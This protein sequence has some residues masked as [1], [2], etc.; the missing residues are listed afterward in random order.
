MLKKFFLLLVGILAFSQTLIFAQQVPNFKYVKSYYHSGKLLAKTITHPND[1]L[2]VGT[3]ALTGAEMILFSYDAQIKSY[4]QNW[5]TPQSDKITKYIEPV[6]RGYVPLGI[7]AGLWCYGYLTHNYKWSHAGLKSF[8]AF[9]FTDAA[10]GLIK[11]SVQRARP[12]STENPYN[13][14]SIFNT[15]NNVS[16]PS[17]HTADAFAL[18]TAICHYIPNK[19]YHIPIYLLASA[20]GLSRIHDNKH[21]ASDVMMGAVIGTVVTKT[22]MKEHRYISRTITPV[23]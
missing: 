22:I 13:I 21:W 12:Y 2:I 17:G 20:V 14:R 23:F 9:I 11:Y 6:G 1:K 19:Y 5:R 7:S 4:V 10:V 8:K 16:F 15:R 3:I 18:A